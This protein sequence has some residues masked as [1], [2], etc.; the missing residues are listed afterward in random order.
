M[1]WI[2]E[3]KAKSRKVVTSPVSGH[4]FTIRK[5]TNTQITEAGLSA[6]IPVEPPKDVAAS[7]LSMARQAD[8]LLI[9]Q[10]RHVVENGAVVPKVTYGSEDNLPEGTVHASW[11]S[12]DEHWLFLT[13]MEFSGIANDKT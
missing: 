7:L 11:I 9:A 6:I 5:L 2:N 12:E 4:D 1:T 3:L 13:I 10:T 8:Q